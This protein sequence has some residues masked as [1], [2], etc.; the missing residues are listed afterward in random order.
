MPPSLLRKIGFIFLALGWLAYDHYRPWASFHSEALAFAGLGFIA[1][2]VSFWRCSSLAPQL[3]TVIFAVALIPW[4]QYA[5]GIIIYAG[6]AVLVSLYVVGFAIAIW[7]GFYLAIKPAECANSDG[8]SSEK[9]I[10]PIFEVIW[11][12]A[13]VSAAIGLLQWLSLQE[14]LGMYVVQTEP[15]DRARA[16]LGQPN[17]LASLLLMGIASFAYG[18]ENKR[19][20]RVGLIVGSIF[21]T[22]VLVLTQSRAGM[23]SALVITIFLLCISTKFESRIKAPYI[24]CWFLIFVAGIFAL[25]HISDFLLMSGVRGMKT[26]TDSERMLIWNQ[27]V[28]AIS[29][30]PILGYGWNQTTAVQTFGSLKVPGD[31]TYT[32]AHNFFLDIIS[33][34]GVPLGLSIISF[35]ALW[36]LSRLYALRQTRACYAMCGLLVVAVHSMFEYPYA[37]GYFLVTTG[38]MIG[39]V[40]AS[41]LKTKTI[42]IKSR[43][44]AFGICTWFAMGSYLAYE[45]LLVEEDFRVVRFEN[46]RI[47]QT[48]IDYKAPNILMLSQMA[49]MLKAA[50]QQASPGMPKADLEN[51]RRASLRFSYGPLS[52]RYALALG[53]N[54]NPAAASRQMAIIRG[55]Y[56]ERYYQAA[57]NVLRQHQRE[58]YPELSQVMAP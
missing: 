52:L 2:N 41:H 48:P 13:V 17:H 39:I 18:Y 55:M 58:K 6:D 29:Q 32:Y 11:F 57:V 26:G 37:Y 49:S 22:L 24:V 31:T 14:P 19:I 36:F 53:L 12:V 9:L 1:L 28:S 46:L 42:K 47:G 44:L 23:V 54:G 5:A 56:G 16:N 51:L 25:P 30:S 27:V 15:G 35:C 43:W 7:T 20:G 38:L 50:R 34:N 4:L 40:E 45:Y 8:V 21:L 33:W 3:I 10:A